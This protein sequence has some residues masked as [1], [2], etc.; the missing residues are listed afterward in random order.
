[1]ITIKEVLTKV[2]FKEFLSFPSQ[3]YKNNQY[4][5][6]FFGDDNLL[7][8]QNKNSSFEYCECRLFL[9]VDGEKVL[10][11]IATII[12]HRYNAE[13]KLNEIRFFKYDVVDNFEASMML[14]NQVKK[15][16]QENGLTSIVGEMGFTQFEHYGLLVEGYDDYAVYD[17]RYNN[18]YVIDHLKK[19]NFKLDHSWT[20]YRI[21]IPDSLDR[22]LDDM[23]KFILKKYNLNLVSI[24]SVKKNDNLADY[25]AKSIALRLKEYDYEYSFNS[26]SEEELD[27]IIGKFK[28]IVQSFNIGTTYYFLITNKDNEAIGFILGIPSLAKLLSKIKLKVKPSLSYLY[29]KANS[30]GDSLDLISVVVRKEYQNLGISMILQNE[31][32]KLCLDNGIKYINTDFDFDLSEAIKEDYKNYKMEKIKTFASFRLDIE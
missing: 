19:L 16:A 2:D 1:M 29:N 7:F 15:V 6:P 17:S 26:I 25:I 31:L 3:L 28:N 20:S 21:T 13:R 27:I 10:G 12:N 32:F 14:L 8:S 9:C 24:T 5:V 18:P 30:K 23:S 22:R 11:R 4:Y